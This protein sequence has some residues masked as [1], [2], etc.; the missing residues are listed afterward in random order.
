MTV[1]LVLLRLAFVHGAVSVGIN[2]VAMGFIFQPLAFVNVS[3]SMNQFASYVGFVLIQVAFVTTP[4]NS[5]LNSSA[6]PMIGFNTPLALINC[7]VLVLD[8]LPEHHG[9]PI[10]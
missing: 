3:I 7:F 2:T 10:I 4:I 8:T 1:L 9:H 6:V 5:D